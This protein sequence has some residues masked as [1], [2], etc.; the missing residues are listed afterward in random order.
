MKL[1]GIN[2]E[3]LSLILWVASKKICE[4]DIYVWKQLTPS[5]LQLNNNLV[6]L[7][8]GLFWFKLNVEGY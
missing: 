1:D 4:S 8:I 2:S 3:I 6:I 5:Q 7:I